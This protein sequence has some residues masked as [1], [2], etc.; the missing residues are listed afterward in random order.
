LYN[1]ID[2]DEEVSESAQPV[3]KKGRGRPPKRKA[4]KAVGSIHG[5]DVRGWKGSK[6]NGYT[7]KSDTIV[8]GCTGTNG[9]VIN[10]SE[11]LVEVYRYVSRSLLEEG[12]IERDDQ[13]AE[14]AEQA[15][16]QESIVQL[17]P[18]AKG[19]ERVRLNQYWFELV[20]QP[21]E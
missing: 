10:D 1:V 16:L 12:D 6:Q 11:L 18:P 19:E 7:P 2:T 9:P 5:T 21:R 4:R 14:R 8:K 13:Q 20:F 17:P 3:I 15:D